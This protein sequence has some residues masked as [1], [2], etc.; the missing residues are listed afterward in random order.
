MEYNPIGEC[1]REA[2]FTCVANASIS[3]YLR[4]RRSVHLQFTL[5]VLIAPPTGRNILH[6]VRG[7]PDRGPRTPSFV[8]HIPRRIYE[9]QFDFERS[10]SNFD[11]LLR[12][13]ISH[14]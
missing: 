1:T 8:T 10:Y 9:R 2:Q 6:T 11:G 7:S 12:S 4:E 5:S 13:G 3:H 14:L